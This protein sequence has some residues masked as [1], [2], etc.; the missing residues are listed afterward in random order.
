M[1]LFCPLSD[2]FFPLEAL[3][4]PQDACR[5]PAGGGSFSVIGELPKI[6]SAI[7]EDR[8]ELFVEVFIMQMGD[9]MGCRRFALSLLLIDWKVCENATQKIAKDSLALE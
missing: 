8:L 1:A 4:F 9:G 5:S 2:L 6:H 7:V 3:F